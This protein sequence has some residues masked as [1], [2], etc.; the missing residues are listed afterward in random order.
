MVCHRIDNEPLH[1]PMM[2]NFTD[3]YKRQPYQFNEL[4]YRYI[5][6]TMV[7]Q[8]MTHFS[9]M[10]TSIL[11]RLSHIEIIKVGI[12]QLALNKW[13]IFKSVMD[14]IE[15]RFVHQITLPIYCCGLWFCYKFDILGR[16]ITSRYKPEKQYEIWPRCVISLMT[17]VCEVMP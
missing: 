12:K 16:S 13:I 17:I 14:W 15:E 5:K 8:P 7:P 3:S 4:T 6:M 11:W 2:V 10:H 1:E 9:C